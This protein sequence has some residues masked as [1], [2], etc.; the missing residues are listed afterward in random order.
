MLGADELSI[1]FAEAVWQAMRLYSE[2]DADFSDYLLG[3]RG[4]EMG[5]KFTYTFDTNASTSDL[6]R[7]VPHT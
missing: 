7:P 3:L 5:A 4:R 6:F 2:G 1:E